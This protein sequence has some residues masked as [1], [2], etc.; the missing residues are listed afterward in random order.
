MPTEAVVAAVVPME[1]VVA[2]EVPMEA[3]VAVV[4]QM[5]VNAARRLADSWLLASAMRDESPQC[6]PLSRCI[7]PYKMAA[8]DSRPS[9]PI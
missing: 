3:A 9:S 1:V 2:V 6:A 4:V 5:V 8:S 7:E